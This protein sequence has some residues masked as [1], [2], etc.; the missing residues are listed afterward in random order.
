MIATS[1]LESSGPAAVTE[2][3]APIATCRSPKTTVNSIFRTFLQKPLR[4]FENR[5]FISLSKEEI[6]N[7]LYL[8]RH[9]TAQNIVTAQNA[10]R[11]RSDTFPQTAVDAS[12]ETCAHEPGP[13]KLNLAPRRS[14]LL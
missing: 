8:T 11:P 14:S 3:I 12:T 6:S 4:I 2:P 10:S 1:A 5:F 9:T 13:Q 7:R